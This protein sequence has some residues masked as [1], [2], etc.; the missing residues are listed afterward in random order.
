[1]KHFGLDY[2]TTTSL[3]YGYS[4]N[5]G[6]YRVFESLSA[7][8]LNENGNVVETG[9]KAW[10]DPDR[11]GFVESPKRGINNLEEHQEMIKALL[12][13]MIECAKMSPES[14]ITLT[15]PYSY[16]VA[17]YGSMLQML[18]ECLE[19]K[20]HR[21]KP[22]HIHTLPEP[23][24]AALFYVFRHLAELPAECHMVVCDIG[25]GTT[26][27]CIIR[28]VKEDGKL[29][30]SVI[31]GGNQP[32]DII[33]GNKFDYEISKKI[34][35]PPGFSS[36]DKTLFCQTLKCD[37]SESEVA[38]G[39]AGDK[40]I[41]MTRPVFEQAIGQ[42]LQELKKMMEA[43]LDRT[44]LNVANGSWYILPI[45][46]SCKIPAIRRCLEEVFVGARQTV[47]DENTIFD[48]VA[49]GAALYSAWSAGALCIEGINEISIEHHTPHEI[50]FHTVDGSWQTLVHENAKDGIHND[51]IVHIVA[52]D[53]NFDV[54]K[55]T[56]T[57]GVIKLRE[58]KA[59]ARPI[60]CKPKKVFSLRGRKPEDIT[61]RLGVEIKN[62][63][64]VRWWIEDCLT[65]EKQ[66]WTIDTVVKS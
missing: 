63:L 47:N 46:G 17:N 55:G 35:F 31:E 26:D 28:C 50:Q 56:Y 3:V 36:F 41:I 40:L 13:K 30:F 60:E 25:G 59:N 5:N 16:G 9:E 27:M 23:V 32:S 53:V 66:E 21:C 65:G 43:M 12:F 48:S 8:K 18:D 52:N 29:V 51:T 33:G 7:V 45:G 20:Y 4:D 11:T 2:G 6:L 37:L 44:K 14:H 10:N 19:E 34:S 64:I 39:Y 57:V 1:M 24:A 58:K 38:T 42:Y 54:E 49:Q 15:V 62:C 22:R 61:L